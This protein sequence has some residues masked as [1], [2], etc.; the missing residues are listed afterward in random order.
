MRR[1]WKRRLVW[2]GVLLGVLLLAL[3]ATVAQAARSLEALVG[4][5]T[6]VRKLIPVA[7]LALL[8]AGIGLR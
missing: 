3:P 4:G 8:A 1:R 5:R 7:V 2:A 6:V